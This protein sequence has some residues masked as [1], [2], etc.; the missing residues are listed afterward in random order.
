[1]SISFTKYIDITSGVAGSGA[2]R[3]RE[4]ILRVFSA[5]PLIPTNAFAEFTSADDVETYFGSTSTEYAIAA[6]YFGFVSKTIQ[7]PQKISFS[8]WVETAVAP[9]VYGSTNATDTLAELV[10]ITAGELTLTIGTVTETMT[11]ITFA[12]SANLA[13]VAT[14]LQTKIRAA[15]TD[16]NWATATVTYN[17]TTG[18][19]DLT[20]G[21]VPTTGT[22][23]VA[24]AA[25]SGV[26]VGVAI[27]WE[28]IDTIFSFG[29]AA[30]TLTNTLIASAAASTNFATF[31][32]IPV[33][34]QDQIEEVA[35]WLNTQNL[36]Y[37]YMV[38]VT[39]TDAA[40]ISESLMQLNGNALTLSPIE[41][42]F[43]ELFPAMILAATD[44]TKANASQNYMYQ[45]YNFDA[46]VNDDADSATYDALR[47]N[48][49]G[50][51]QTAG[52][53][54]AF[55]QR[56][57]LTGVAT[58]PSDINVFANE[59]WFKSSVGDAFLSA[60]LALNEIPANAAGRATCITIIQ[61][62][63][64]T[65]LLNG[66]ISPGQTFT[67]TQ[68]QT[69]AQITNDPKAYLQVQNIGYWLDVNFS[70]TVTTDGR[71]EYQ[72]N[73][74]LVYAKNNA[75]RKVV[76]THVLI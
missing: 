34:D 47:V 69:I 48:Y 52:Q 60:L 65:A 76:G 30:V 23:P 66:T 28:D 61:G 51:T 72:A 38:P 55:Y 49:Y 11:A 3:A 54:I 64:T 53:N 27:G 58:S 21:V 20:G 8:S 24:V 39:S 2:V 46:S 10:A 57:V 32:F 9:N 6:E 16:T 36:M 41:G 35:T 62:V 43:P 70:S 73:Y 26:D 63:I 18:A 22:V 17:A 37:M 31:S 15:S 40:A 74:T 19:F 13:A 14:A 42:A 7:S 5:N 71:T 68:L 44:Y 33:L 1:M 67:T 56:G 12:G 29:S 50:Q 25:S 59:I 4:F 75:I 45:Q